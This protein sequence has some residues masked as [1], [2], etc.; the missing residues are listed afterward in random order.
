MRL[1]LDIV[2]AMPDPKKMPD[3]LRRRR[4]Q[5]RSDTLSDFCRPVQSPAERSLFMECHLMHTNPKSQRTDWRKVTREFNLQVTR[6]WQSGANADLW[7]KSEAHL[8]HFEKQLVMQASL[9][10]MAQTS[11]AISGLQAPAST[12]QAVNPPQVPHTILQPPGPGVVPVL[13][14]KEPGKGGKGKPKKCK[15]CTKLGTFG[16]V[17][18]AGHNCALFLFLTGDPRYDTRAKLIAKGY[19]V[20]E[21]PADK[22]AAEALQ[23]QKVVNAR[24]DKKRKGRE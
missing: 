13:S 5:C 22:E 8:K 9:A 12:G 2:K 16:T 23:R 1:V 19:D 21:I 4:S 10:E 17:M 24:Q 11:S 7:L 15:A 18:R 6:S 20:S 14:A 3:F